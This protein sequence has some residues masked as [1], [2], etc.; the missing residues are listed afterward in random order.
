MELHKNKYFS[1]FNRN[2]YYTI[3]FAEPNVI[4]LPII[5]DSQLLMVKAKRPVLSDIT[6]EFPAGDAIGNE[7]I[8]EAALRE[9][10]EETGIKID[11]TKRLVRLP[12]LN[13]IP[14]RTPQLLNIFQIDLSTSEYLGRTSHDDEVEEIVLLSFSETIEKILSGEIYVATPI[15]ILFTYLIKQKLID[16]KNSNNSK[17]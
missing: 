15:A 17:R 16:L 2:G 4:V 5:D 3:E 6:F 13:T 8:E 12:S 14:S 11:N 10:Y 7:S 1:V 9:L